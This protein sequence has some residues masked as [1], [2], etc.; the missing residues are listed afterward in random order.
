MNS[1]WKRSAGAVV[2]T[3]IAG[4]ASAQ[5]PDLLNAFEMGGRALGMGGALYSNSTD[6]TA[7]Y[8]N[9]AGLGFIAQGTAEITMRNRPSANTTLT[10][11]F[12]IPDRD[13]EGDFGTNAITFGGFAVPMAGGTLGISY[14]LGGIAKE[15]AFGNNL[16]NPD[17]QGQLITHNELFRVSTDFFTLAFGKKTGKNAS[18]GFGL[19]VA[20]QG[21]T[22]R[23]IQSDQN[24]VTLQDVDIS[25]DA[26]GFGGIIGIQ[27]AP[28]PNVSY[29]FSFRS[30]IKLSGYDDAQPYGDEIPGR[31]QGGIAWRIDGIR[32]GRDF[33]VGGVDVMYFLSANDGDILETDG[34]LSAGVGLEYNWSQGF[35]YIPL[36]LGFRANNSGGGERFG[37]RDAFTFGLGYRPNDNRFSF[38]IN[39]VNV[40][41]QSRPD[42][43][44]T[45]GFPIGK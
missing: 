26:T 45:M 9:P 24:N 38:D 34:Q 17:V 8:W 15:R 14:A 35:G 5:V 3:M 19:V 18:I 1:A 12:D 39:V 32:G 31:V 22:N 28:N 37:P 21:L 4:G 42:V 23:L 10:G 40:T 30:P 13:S 11:R 36:R 33:L 20:R 43:S 29:G 27:I 25:E 7:S 2:L 44:F 6:A 16:T 41:G